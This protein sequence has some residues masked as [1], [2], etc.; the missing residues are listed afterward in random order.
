[1]NALSHTHKHALARQCLPKGAQSLWYTHH[2]RSVAVSATV[3]VDGHE[4][5]TRI[6]ANNGCRRH[7]QPHWKTEVPLDASQRRHVEQ[8]A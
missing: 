8:L 5:G 3:G 6:Q 7:A 1:M 4:A 2:A